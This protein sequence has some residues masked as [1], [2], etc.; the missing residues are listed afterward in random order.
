MY[1][2]ARLLDCRLISARES[3]STLLKLTSQNNTKTNCLSLRDVFHSLD[4]Y[5]FLSESFCI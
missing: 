4:V 2:N 5:C 3:H 1:L